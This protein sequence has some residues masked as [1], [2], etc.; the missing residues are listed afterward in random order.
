MA[1]DRNPG[2]GK[3]QAALLVPRGVESQLKRDTFVLTPLLNS[4]YRPIREFGKIQKTAE[5]R[6]TEGL[7]RRALKV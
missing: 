5:P 6:K 1:L 3:S 2:G 7:G 4:F